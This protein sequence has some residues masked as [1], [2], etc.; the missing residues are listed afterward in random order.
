MTKSER[1]AVRRMIRE[2]I[3]DTLEEIVH[4]STFHDGAA[5]TPAALQQR[6]DQLR[7]ADHD[8]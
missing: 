5:V 8:H 3:A 4:L 7:K 1:D 6:A 2:A